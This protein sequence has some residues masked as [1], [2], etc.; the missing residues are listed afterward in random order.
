MVKKI[1][2]LV[3]TEQH[4]MVDAVVESAQQI[5]QAGLGAFARAQ[6]EGDQLFDTLVRE[7]LDLHHLTQKMAGEK[8]HGVADRVNRLAENVG[9][10]ASGSLGKIER[11]FE[12]RVARSMRA[13]GVP[14]LEDVKAL[15][16]EVADLQAAVTASAPPKAVRRST[17][18][19]PAAAAPARHALKVA[20]VKSPER[21]A[22]K[23]QTKA[24]TRH[25]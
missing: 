17:A 15:R 13:L 8:V 20:P 9:R 6:K 2:K 21:T 23:R 5:W 3:A 16:Q 4:A 1:K 12:D 14:T 18:S 7:G 19:R 25:H 11:L 10:Q 24:I 22:V